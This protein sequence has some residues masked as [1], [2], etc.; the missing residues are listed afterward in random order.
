M[1][2]SFQVGLPDKFL[3]LVVVCAV[4]YALFYLLSAAE[5]TYK[6]SEELPRSAVENKGSEIR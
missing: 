4:L 2:H 3:A 5:N 6:R 1:I